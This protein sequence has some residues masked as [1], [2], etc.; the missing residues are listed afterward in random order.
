MKSRDFKNEISFP[1][2]IPP[3]P[4]KGVTGEAKGGGG[5]TETY[6]AKKIM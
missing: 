4:N 6:T 1:F 2:R 3:D 5:G